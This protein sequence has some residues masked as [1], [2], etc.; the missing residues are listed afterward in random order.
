VHLAEQGAGRQGHRTRE[1]WTWHEFT[2]TA[3]HFPGQTFYHSGLLAEGH[4]KRVFFAGDSGAPTGLDDYC[5]GNRVF[6][7]PGRGSRFCLDLWR[8]CA[9]DYIVNQH[10]D[11][12]FCLTPEQIAYMDEMLKE[13]ERLIVEITPWSHANFATDEWWIRTYPYEQEAAAGASI[14]IDVEFTNHGAQE[15]EATVAPVLP[16]GW[17]SEEPSVRIT[18][19]PETSGSR[20]AALPRPDCAARITLGVPPAQRP[21]CT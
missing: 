5:C 19:P 11:R 9:P 20:D 21:A 15:T 13:R 16:E 18:A 4:G 12:A 14:S 2:L 6:L 7:G 1:S 8:K 17:V 10:Q 3:F